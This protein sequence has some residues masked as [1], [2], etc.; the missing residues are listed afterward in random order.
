LAFSFFSLKHIS[1][2]LQLHSTTWLDCQDM[3]RLGVDTKHCTRTVL[4]YCTEVWTRLNV[5][6]WRVR[7]FAA[8]SAGYQSGQ[9]T[10]TSFA[11]KRNTNINLSK[12]SGY[13][14]CHHV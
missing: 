7:I 13:F 14:T 3:P 8:W 1:C 5:T 6:L 11:T 9:F 12:P 2:T 10:W 4:G